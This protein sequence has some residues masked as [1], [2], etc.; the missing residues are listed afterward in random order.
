MT[1]DSKVSL[2]LLLMGDAS[3]RFRANSF[4]R[5]SCPGAV[6]ASTL[7]RIV[8]ELFE[9]PRR[10]APALPLH[11]QNAFASHY[12]LQSLFCKLSRPFSDRAFHT[13]PLFDHSHLP[14]TSLLSSAHSSSTCTSHP[15]SF[16][17]CA[18]HQASTLFASSAAQTGP[19]C[20]ARQPHVK[21][22]SSFWIARATHHRSSSNCASVNIA[23]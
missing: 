7:T 9:A 14:L 23:P 12:S 21:S 15:L 3:G 13:V 11:T 19:L 1:D 2:T 17:T 16:Q 22:H 6:L 20:A 8:P 5:G 18:L 10:V 4:C